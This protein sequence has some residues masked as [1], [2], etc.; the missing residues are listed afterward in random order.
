[1]DSMPRRHAC[2]NA[3]QASAP[4][5]TGAA[6]GLDASRE[7]FVGG[8]RGPA[9]VVGAR[10]RHDSIQAGAPFPDAAT[11][12][13]EASRGTSFGGI[14]GPNGVEGARPRHGS[15]QAGAPFPAA[16]VMG[17]EASRGAS[18][19]GIL[20]PAGVEGARP[21]HGSLH[22]SVPFNPAA[23]MGLE[24]FR[25]A[26]FGG[27]PS[28]TAEK[29]VRSS[30][31]GSGFQAGASDPAVHSMAGH[32]SSLARHIVHWGSVPANAS[33]ELIQKRT[34]GAL[35]ACIM[36]M[37]D[38]AERMRK[39]MSQYQISAMPRGFRCQSK[40][41]IGTGGRIAI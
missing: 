5:P 10:P 21:R 30:F 18:F 41:A 14:P 13:L 19:D 4:L 2:P 24:A 16:A 32:R 11:M 29:G 23:T 3:V 20:G 7:V 34:M 12:G 31:L 26:A 37:Q 39:L 1:M 28:P 17:L 27:I 36:E 15:L 6:M 33:P 40:V 25:G 38:N 9:G 8:I 35:A 22:A